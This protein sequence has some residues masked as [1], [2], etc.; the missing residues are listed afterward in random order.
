MRLNVVVE[1]LEPQGYRAFVRQP[2]DL[3]I[4]ATTRADAIEQLTR[5]LAEKMGTA[6]VVEVD[7]PA[8]PIHP[9]GKL[10][11]SWRD[12]PDRTEFEENIRDYR[13]QI[14]NDPERL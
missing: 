6:D 3:S 5:L 4:V 14:D 7:I 10:C 2:W 11:G 9:W 13:H 1:S 12:H 8:K